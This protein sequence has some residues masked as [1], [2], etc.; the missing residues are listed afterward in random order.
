M[1]TSVKTGEKSGQR[2][3]PKEDRQRWTPKEDRQL[4]DLVDAEATWPLIAVA[5]KRDVEDV[6]DRARKLRREVE[7]GLR[8]KAK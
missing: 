6:Q 1:I 5:L 7:L 8:T 4:L 2:W 3:T